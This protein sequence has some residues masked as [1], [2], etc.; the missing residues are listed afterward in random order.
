MHIDI[1]LG[2]IGED[3]DCQAGR[4]ICGSIHTQFQYRIKQSEISIYYIVKA[5]IGRVKNRA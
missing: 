5:F 1:G 3:F 2:E 4:E